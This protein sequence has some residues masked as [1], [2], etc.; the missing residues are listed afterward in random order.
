LLV[1]ALAAAAGLGGALWQT[2][3]WADDPNGVEKAKSLSRAFRAAAKEVIPTVVKIK[4]VT[5][6]KVIEG[7]KGR[8]PREN[9]FKGTPFE[10][11]FD[12]APLP[13]FGFYRYQVPQREGL[14]SG[15]IIDRSGIILT[16]NHVLEGADEVLVKLADGRQF[17][18]SD[19]K[20]DEESDLAVLRIHADASL[21]AAKLGDSEALDIGDWVL[22]IGNPFE[23]E[24][25]VSAGIISA[26]GR[27]L[28]AGRRASFLQTDAAINPGNS[29]GPLV[30]L[31]GEV[32][33]INTAIASS[34]GGYQ[35]VG[36][37]IPINL[38]KW[39][40]QQLIQSGSVQ[41]AWLGVGIQ[42][43]DGDL[44]RQLHAENRKGVA[45]S[46]VR[47]NSPAAAAGFQ[48]DDVIVSFGE[49]AVSS[50]RELQEL[51]ERSAI[52][53]KQ[54][55]QVLREG[56]PV[57]LSVVVKALPPDA[58]TASNRPSRRGSRPQSEFS[59][60]EVKDL[61]LRVTELSAQL[62][63]RLG[64]QELS[65]VVISDVAAASVAASAGLEEGMLIMRVGKK[66][67][68]SVAEFRA[69]LKGQSLKEGILLLVRTP[70]GNRFVVLQES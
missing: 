58:E 50:H 10:D 31:D 19:I 64:F 26:K 38:A 55:V 67:V 20:T 62:A 12:E 8:S 39:V 57:T 6:P 24:S 4:S 15:V 44:A 35:G 69:A 7:P 59:S 37:A 33:G 28:P 32:V 11:F 34:S 40:T 61:G 5:K 13:G 48:V 36:F 68:R 53:S 47:A 70:Y 3:T 9:P 17:K 45:V 16:N 25:T 51:V 56:K 29:G 22:A 60:Y 23:L 27:S 1:W 43:L 46:D 42:E 30:N 14:G 66:P 65:G 49:H 54:Q 52:G 63:E 2:R 41:R 18:G 21:P